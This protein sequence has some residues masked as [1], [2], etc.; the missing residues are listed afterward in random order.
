MFDVGRSM[1][2]VQV[3]VLQS[4][5]L[6]RFLSCFRDENEFYLVLSVDSIDF[7]VS[8]NETGAK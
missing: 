7:R 5:Y 2:N 6:N 3:F 1:F 4:I 8:P